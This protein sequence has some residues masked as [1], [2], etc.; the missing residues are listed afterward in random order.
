M[1]NSEKMVC[2]TVQINI[3]LSG[4]WNHGQHKL[5]LRYCCCGRD[6]FYKGR[7]ATVYFA[8]IIE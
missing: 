8:A 1:E 2:T 6:E 4:R 5:E 7:K 3:S